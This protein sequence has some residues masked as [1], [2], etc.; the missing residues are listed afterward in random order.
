MTDE[1]DAIDAQ[2]QAAGELA[3]SW[4]EP[5]MVVGLGT[6]STAVHAIRA[7][8]ARID[9]GELREVVGIPTSRASEAEAITAGIPLTT[10]A[11]HTVVDLTIDGA[12]DVD[13]ALDLIK[14]AGSALWREKMVAQA[15]VREVIVVDDGKLSPRLGPPAALPVEV[16]QFGWRPEAE[17]LDDMGAA[18]TV[19]RGADGAEV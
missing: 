7:I 15:S 17:Y 1:T 4:V 10:L 8:G 11:E 6:G 18:V 2:K 19:R 16:A 12:D 5:G 14:G 3:G 13:P 9:S